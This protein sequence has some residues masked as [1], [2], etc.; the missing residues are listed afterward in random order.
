[1]QCEGCVDA[2]TSETH[3]SSQFAKLIDLKSKGG[4]IVPSD[5]VVKVCLKA[6]IIHRRYFTTPNEQFKAFE[7]FKKVQEVLST[8]I[9]Q[10]ILSTVNYCTAN[11]KL[12]NHRPLL[13]KLIASKYLEIRLHHVAKEYTDTLKEK[14]KRSRQRANKLTHFSGL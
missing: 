13:I 1:M 6:E 2:L 9:G 7:I 12:N 5:D 14:H 8:C 11:F 4:Q 3:Y 10:E